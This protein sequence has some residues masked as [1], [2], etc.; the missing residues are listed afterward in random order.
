VIRA[1]ND[2][3]ALRVGGRRRRCERGVFPANRASSSILR[4]TIA[5]LA[6]AGREQRVGAT[7][8]GERP[9]QAAWAAGGFTGEALEF[10]RVD[11]RAAAGAGEEKRGDFPCRTA[12]T[13]CDGS[14]TGREAWR[15]R[16]A[17]ANAGR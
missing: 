2:F 12:D 11:E 9:P 8:G 16:R 6:R 7:P 13:A 10:V 1:Q 5:R 17:R 4:S 14:G 15:V 3:G